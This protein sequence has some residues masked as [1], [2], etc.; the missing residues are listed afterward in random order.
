M[1]IHIYVYTDNIYIYI[2]I[3]AALKQMKGIQFFVYSI[4][5]VPCCCNFLGGSRVI[6]E[7][8]KATFERQRN[9]LHVCGNKSL[10]QR[11]DN[12]NSRRHEK[13]YGHVTHL[14]KDFVQKFNAVDVEHCTLGNQ[15]TRYVG[16]ASKIIC[17]VGRL[18]CYV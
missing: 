11:N 7:Q 10:H 15:P 12:D 6:T 14:K 1:C 5:G 3:L 9:V 8:G 2:H 13:T 4:G 16:R 17:K 18:D